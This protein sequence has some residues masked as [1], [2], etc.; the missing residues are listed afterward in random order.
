ML[1]SLDYGPS[2]CTVCVPLALR[3]SLGFDPSGKQSVRMGG[4]E[5]ADRSRITEDKW[6]GGQ[7]A[8]GWAGLVFKNLL[9][10]QQN[11]TLSILQMLHQGSE[12]SDVRKHYGEE[13]RCMFLEVPELPPWSL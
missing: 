9:H 2:V 8:A 3:S 1:S 5:K 6:M 7:W 10:Q 13:N 4:V 12:C 11:S